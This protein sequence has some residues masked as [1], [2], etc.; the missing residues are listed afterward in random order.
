MYVSYKHIT[1]R[2]VGTVCR[3]CASQR[4]KGTQGYA[5]SSTSCLRRQR[6]CKRCSERKEDRAK[7]HGHGKDSEGQSHHDARCTEPEIA[8][9]HLFECAFS[10]FCPLYRCYTSKMLRQHTKAPGL[11]RPVS[12]PVPGCSVSLQLLPAQRPSNRWHYRQRQGGVFLASALAHGAQQGH[13]ANGHLPHPDHDSH[14]HCSHDHDHEHHHHHHHHNHDHDHDH[15][16]HFPETPVSRLLEK[17]GILGLAES[18]SLSTTCTVLAISCYTASLILSISA[19][20]QLAPVWASTLQTATLSASLVLLGIPQL[21]ESVCLAAAGVIDTHV[22][23]ALAAFGTLYMGM[24]Q[25]VSNAAARTA[26]QHRAA[27]RLRWQRPL[28]TQ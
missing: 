20:Q 28:H 18:M 26:T 8:R 21:V 5:Y 9:H 1:T 15:H 27:P 3:P 24:A 16:H 4:D 23:M 2:E 11:T 25:E 6:A 13:S 22:L 14:S 10:L 7:T 17:V 12:G 19:V